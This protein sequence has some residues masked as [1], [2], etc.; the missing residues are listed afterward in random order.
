MKQEAM[1]FG[2]V[3]VMAMIGSF[4]GWQASLI[5]FFLAPFAAVVIAVAQWLLTRRTAIAFGPYLCLG[6]LIV[7]L[8]WPTIWIEHAMHL[9]QLGTMIP[10]ILIACLGLMYVLLMIIQFLKR[11]AGVG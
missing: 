11:L 3:T 4:W 8:A 9:F 2:D 6:T 10:M 5:I 1:G 7:M